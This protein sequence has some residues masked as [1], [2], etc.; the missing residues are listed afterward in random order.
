MAQTPTLITSKSNRAVMWL[1]SLSQKKYREKEE[2]FL[3][4]GDKLYNEAV[5]ADAPISHIVLREDR[6]DLLDEALAYCETHSETELLLLSDACFSKVC[7]EKAPQGVI[8]VLKYLDFSKYYYIINKEI[9]SGLDMRGTVFLESVQDPGNVGAV[10]RSA[11]AFG[12]SDVVLSND[13]ADLYHP[14]TLRASM[15]ALFH[16]RTHV[17]EDMAQAVSAFKSCGRRVFAAMP[18][19]TASPLSCASM[20]SCDGIVIGNEGHGISASVAEAAGEYVY[21]PMTDAVESLNASVAA[22]VLIWELMKN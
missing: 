8:V 6:K 21:I 2:R 20:T 7:T 5:K 12:V 16:L 10:L 22:S 15:G 14:K 18:S 4:E 3:C 13:C 17:V 1:A 19:Q 9:F 11:A